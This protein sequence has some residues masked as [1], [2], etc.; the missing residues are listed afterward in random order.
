VPV[1]YHDLLYVPVDYHDLLYVPVDYH[2]LLKLKLRKVNKVNEMVNQ[3]KK[4]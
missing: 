3:G 1:D 2:D 4:W